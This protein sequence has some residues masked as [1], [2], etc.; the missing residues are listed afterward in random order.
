MILKKFRFAIIVL[1]LFAGI[2]PVKS[3][4]D[5]RVHSVFL[6]NFTRLVAWPSDYRTGDFVIAVY[7]DSPITRELEEMAKTRKAGTQN[8]VVVN[9]NSPTD[10]TRCHII[11]IP[12]TQRRHIETIVGTL[13]SRNINALIVT[14]ARGVIASGA[15]VNFTVVEGRQRFEL[16]P[17]NA[18]RMGL[19][20]GAEIERLAILAE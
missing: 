16:S 19:T 10:I 14:D 3:Q 15:V 6:Y 8:I 12:A 4:T 17:A 9:F 18:A 2:L 13:R 5:F 20:L 7:G 1:L 11:Y